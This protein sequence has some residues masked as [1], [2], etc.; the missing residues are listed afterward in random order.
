MEFTKVAMIHKGQDG[1]VWG[2]YLF[3]FDAD[4]NEERQDPENGTLPKLI[5]DG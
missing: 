3:R 1:A 4:G 2:G 5:A